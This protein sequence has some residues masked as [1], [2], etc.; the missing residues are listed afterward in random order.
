M[1]SA[2]MKAKI[3]RIKVDQGK[4]GLFYATSPDLKGLLVGESTLEALDRAI[5][6]A[7]ADLYL[8]CGVK[9]IVTKAEDGEDEY[10]PWIAISAEVAKLAMAASL[11]EATKRA[12]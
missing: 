2:S 6:T 4:A 1:T 9:V 12:G 3:V 5:P 10:P 11:A 8:A 7:I